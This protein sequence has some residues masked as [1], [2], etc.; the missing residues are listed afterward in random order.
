MVA[1]GKRIAVGD[2]P[3]GAVSA[4]EGGGGGGRRKKE[5]RHRTASYRTPAGGGPGRRPTYRQNILELGV[6]L[7]RG[8]DDGGPLEVLHLRPFAVRLRGRGRV[9]RCQCVSGAM[10]CPHC[11]M[12]GLDAPLGHPPP[13]P[14]L[15]RCVCLTVHRGGVGVAFGGAFWPLATDPLWVRTWFGRVDGAPG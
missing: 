8:G 7:G 3:H 2:G 5:R 4:G 1:G 11:A 9:S 15:C 10:A 6:L 14:P 13:P 12:R